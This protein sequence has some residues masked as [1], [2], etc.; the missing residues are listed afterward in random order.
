MDESCHRIGRVLLSGTCRQGLIQGV[1]RRVIVHIFP[2]M[3]FEFVL[4]VQRGE[5]VVT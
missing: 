3:T 2:E 4:A 5:F 1:D